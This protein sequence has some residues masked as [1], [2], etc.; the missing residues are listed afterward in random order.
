MRHVKGPE[1][2]GQIAVVTGGGRGIGAAIAIRYAEEGA[3]VAVVGRTA[4]DLEATVAAV[5]ASGRRG[6]ALQADLTDVGA[7][8]AVFDRVDG[9]LGEVS[10][11]VTSVGVQPT[12]PSLEVSEADW[13]LTMD[14]NAK[15]V[16]FCCQAAGRRFARHRRG[17]IVNIAS[18]FSVVAYPEFCAYNASKG[19][20]LQLTRTLA[21]E[22]AALGINVNAIGPTAIRTEMTAAYLDDPEFLET[23]L[24]RL[25]AGRIGQTSD[26]TGAAVFLASP[27]A[28]FVHGQLLLVDGGYTLV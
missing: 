21:S 1:L 9:E 10:I 5:E 8:D 14:T 2:E 17:K 28:D 11:L 22:W 25:P 18:T 19:A 12:G 23:F 3:D 16:F 24:P 13:D 15:S 27:A 20:V 4:A 7:I 6:L 26:I